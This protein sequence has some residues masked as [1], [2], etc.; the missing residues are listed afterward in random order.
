MASV[1]F[2]LVAVKAGRTFIPKKRW[3]QTIAMSNDR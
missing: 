2:V 1:F 3:Q